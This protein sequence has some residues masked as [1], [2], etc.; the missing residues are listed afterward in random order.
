[1]GTFLGRTGQGK[2]VGKPFADDGGAKR[3]G[4]T[5]VLDTSKVVA[6]QGTRHVKRE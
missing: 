4:S 2:G 3:W 1:M 5:Q 6:R